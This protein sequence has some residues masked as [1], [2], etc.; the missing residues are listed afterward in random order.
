MVAMHSDGL[1]PRSKAS[2]KNMWCRV[3]R[4][5]SG[6]DERKGIRR[7]PRFAVNT[8]KARDDS[9]KKRKVTKGMKGKAAMC[10]GKKVV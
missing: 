4:G 3:G 5:R 6:F 2:I 10:K 1:E 9:P 7:D 8:W